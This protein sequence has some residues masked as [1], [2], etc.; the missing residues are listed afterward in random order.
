MVRSFPPKV[1]LLLDLYS[2]N[3]KPEFCERERFYSRSK[4]DLTLLTTNP[5]AVASSLNVGQFHRTVRE[6]EMK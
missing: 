3:R 6:F 4:K 2:I 5:K 1:A